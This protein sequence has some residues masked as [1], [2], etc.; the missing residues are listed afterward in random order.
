M[1]QARIF[2][3]CL[4]AEQQQ[5]DTQTLNDFLKQVK[6]EKIATKFILQ[7]KPVWHV[8]VFYDATTQETKNKSTVMLNP[9]DT[10][11]F[12]A[13]Q[14]WRRE[15]SLSLHLPAF[16]VCTNKELHEIAQIKPNQVEDFA[17]IKGFGK[18][19]TEK[20]STEILELFNS[21]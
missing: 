13:L 6:V 14:T 3:I 21:L 17:K 11:I 18:H 10:L 12:K 2:Q 16:M 5:L 4:H 20:F 7:E 1:L 15:K 8:L 19:K 9:E